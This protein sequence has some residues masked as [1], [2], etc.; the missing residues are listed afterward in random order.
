[1]LPNRLVEAVFVGRERE[2]HALLTCL[3]AAVVGQGRLV[4]LT[5]EAGIG[6]TRTAL[7]FA[8][9][10]RSRGTQVLIGRG[11][12]DIGVPPFWPWVQMVRTYLATHDPD[13]IRT[14]MGRGAADIAQIIPDVQEC[15]P[16]LP[17]PPSLAPEHARFRFFESFTTFLTK[18]AVISPLLLILDDLQ[19]ADTPS[20]LLLQFLA[21]EVAA[22]RVVVVGTYRDVELPVSHPFRHTLG[23]VAREPV[24]SSV[25]LHGLSEQAVAQ[26]IESTTGVPPT[27][28]M[29]T[30]VHQRTEGNPFFLIEVIQLLTTEGTY[31]ALG[32]AQA[33]LE[34]PV[35]QRV[36]DVV[37]R[38]LQTLSADCQQL[39]SMAAVVGREFHLQVVAAVAAQAHRPLQHSLLDL[40]DEALAAR[41]ITG[42]PQ[43]LGHYSFAHA[44]IRETLYEELPVRTR[45]RLHQQVGDALE[46]LCW[47][48][49]EPYLTELAAHFLAAAQG[50]V[51]VEKAITYALQAAEYATALLA[52][53]EAAHHY[54]QALQL[55]EF[56]PSHEVQQCDVL[57]AL[58]D[59]QRK[60][61]TIMA[62]RETFERAAG[63][64]KRLGT[65]AHLA[66]AALSFAT[67][68][69]GISVQGGVADSLLIG[70]LE[71]ALTALPQ[72]DS[73]LRARV[74]GRLAMELYWSSTREQ[75][76]VISQ[77][78]VEMAR[79]LDDSAT[80]ASTLHATLVALRGP[81]HPH[82]RLATAAE[83]I[84]L[85]EAIG[86]KEL[87]LRGY[88]WRV[89]ALLE[90]G[91]IQ[92]VDQDMAAYGQ[93]AE[94]LRQPLYLW[95]LTIWQ[96]MRAELRGD[97][98][99]AEQLAQQALAMGQRAQDSDAMQC[100]IVQLFVIRGG[101]KS[102]HAVELPT[103]DFAV[104][105]ASIPG[106]RSALALL[107]VSMD[108]DA[109]ARREFEYFA[110]NDFADLPRH[111]Y[112]MIT[113]TNLAQVCV[114]LQDRARA[115][116]LY[117]CLLPFA[118]QCV[119]VEPGLVCLG[120][121]AR[122]LGQL[123]MALSRWDEAEA[124][125]MAAVQ[126]NT[127]LGARPVLAQTQRH[128]ATMLLARQWPGDREKA[129]ELLHQALA[130]GQE[131]AMDEHIRHVHALLEQ[132]E[133]QGASAH[134]AATL[135]PPPLNTTHLFR[136]EGDYWTISYHDSIFRLKHVRGLHYIAH[137]LQHPHQEWHVFDL[138]TLA[139]PPAAWSSMPMGPHSTTAAPRGVN[140]GD[141]GEILD[142]QART[143]YKQRLQELREELAEAQRA[144][145]VG[146]GAAVQQ[147]IDMLLQQLAAAL[148]VGGQSRR[149]ASQAERARV[150]VTNGIRAALAKIAAYSPLL[151]Q[152]LTLTIKTG[153]FCSYTP[154]PHP[155]MVWQF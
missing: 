40:L 123:A 68:F 77:Q 132:A 41:L 34:L 53:E 127:L 22:M 51:A 50:G 126:R 83:I 87:V 13:V 3:E 56:Y 46:H 96:A 71:E 15:V 64:A 45:V 66:R 25:L 7:E 116:Q 119:V 113:L 112:W 39:L 84:R 89:V 149:A 95:V 1:V 73:A 101:R 27:A 47:P 88:I 137:L 93:R 144:N 21:R 81:E 69:A 23:T 76:A 107:Y 136:Q 106:W 117:Q 120:S 110:A 31:A 70:L 72:E 85:A 20:L 131:L 109:E 35:P 141:A 135:M 78:A 134:H 108:R 143:A 138:V 55:L 94:E 130:V 4:F 128:Y 65:P 100:F 121:A 124:H 18:A 59:A 82:D 61:G 30:A 5:G 10:A 114:R 111:A 97:F 24:V 80:L 17:I 33:A 62:A 57:L 63:F 148:G 8:T 49:L 118:E 104:Q 14:A 19:W 11:I 146:R 54:Q 152:H 102:L 26:F 153:L 92:A 6:K 43:S 12:E 99:V 105:Y 44:L 60:A 29:I 142:P 79:R 52:Y 140:L 147:E 151:A 32:N 37:T 129:M 67:G 36:R 42:V 91:D 145:D 154:P 139:R 48:H 28:A 98:A 75:R 86:D 125:F 9:L 2:M 103:R 58:G 16:D 122:F 155:P 115:V 74:L 150:N 133:C 38:R 90:L